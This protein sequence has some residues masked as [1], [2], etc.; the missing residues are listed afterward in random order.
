[1]SV[2]KIALLLVS[3]S[4][5]AIP[6][7]AQL[8]VEPRTEN[9]VTFVSGG[10][11]DEGVQQIRQIEKEYD[12]RLLFA[13]QGSGEYLS[14][15]YVKILDKNGNA[16]VDTKSDG[17]YFLAKLSPGKYDVIAESR[18][19]SIE[20]RVE[21]THGHAVSQSLYWPAEQ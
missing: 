7:R 21:I 18:G 6:V 13:V 14:G 10:V 17:P 9:G 16:L 12:L 5:F 11:G 3:M 8:A 15:V 19:K 2:I 20:K 1:M 4:L